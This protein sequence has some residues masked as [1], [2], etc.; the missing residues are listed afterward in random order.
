M[1]YVV[2]DTVALTVD[3]PEHGLR[4][5]A[6]GAVVDVYSEPNVA[7]EVEFCNSFGRTR[8]MLPLTP[9]QLRLVKR[10]ELPR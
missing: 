4:P 10:S 3:M 7:Y 1:S 8:A 2:F 9:E 5:G 6:I